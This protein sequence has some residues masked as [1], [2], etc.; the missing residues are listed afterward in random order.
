MESPVI[1]PLVSQ[2]VA[3]PGIL[4]E[5]AHYVKCSHFTDSKFSEIRNQVSK[6]LVAMYIN[7]VYV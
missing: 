4:E 3:Q 2:S 7:A 1:G 5:H 6:A